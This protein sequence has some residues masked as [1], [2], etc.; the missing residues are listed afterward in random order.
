MKTFINPL[1]EKV[2]NTLDFN[3]SM[4]AAKVYGSL[5]HTMDIG[6]YDDPEMEKVLINR[7]K[8]SLSLSS[9]SVPNKDCLHIITE[10]YIIGGHTRLMEKLAGMHEIPPDLLIT[11]YSDEKALERCKKI[12]TA[13]HSIEANDLIETV[14][15]IHSFCK[16][17]KRIVLHIHADDIATV[18]A[19]G[20]IQQVRELNVYFVNHAD[21]AFTFGSA[22]A[23]YYFQL[24]SYGARLDKLKTIAGQ[25]S[26]LGIPVSDIRPEKA[27]TSS[28]VS[29]N[30]SFFSSGAA[31]KFKPFR[32]ENINPLI[33]KILDKWPQTTFTIVGVSMLT[34]FWWWP[35][36][37][38]YGKRLRLLR[39]LPYDQFISLTREADFYVDSYPFPGGTAF[40]EQILAGKRGIGLMSRV[41]GYSPADKLK[42]PSVG[43]VIDTIDHYQDDGVVEEIVAV[44]GYEAVKKR[45]LACLYQN[46]KSSF[47]METLVPWGGDTQSLVV[48]NKVFVPISPEVMKYL[49]RNEKKLFLR[50]FLR[51]SLFNKAYI[52]WNAIK[53]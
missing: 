7:A 30:P 46:E 38:R 12:F 17:Y 35:L 22:V 37:L 2:L 16:D 15:Q 36:K 51:M 1:R 8:E 19:C 9:E 10:A 42:R 28:E 43:D 44:N 6:R 29:A 47:D 34:N 50:I 13:V 48:R 21:H 41:Q 20:L 49:Y 3:I 18:V 33:A 25:T 24:S 14:K 26:F 11:R 23:N 53:K 39:Y 5:L 45:Y 27:T 31:M 4:Q 32:G 52:S 40:A